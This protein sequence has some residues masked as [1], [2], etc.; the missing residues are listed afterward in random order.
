MDS[1]PREN[2]RLTVEDAMETERTMI[3]YASD[4]HAEAGTEAMEAQGWHVVEQTTRQPREIPRRLGLAEMIVVT[5]E[6]GE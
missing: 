1:K 2:P 5:Y 3:T 4:E 6:R